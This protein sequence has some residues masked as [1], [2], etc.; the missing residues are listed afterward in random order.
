MRQIYSIASPQSNIIQTSQLMTSFNSVS[1]QT[2]NE[3]AMIKSLQAMKNL[4]V[5][6]YKLDP[7]KLSTIT[8]FLVTSEQNY[9]EL[10]SLVEYIDWLAKHLKKNLVYKNC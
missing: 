2:C 6:R 7:S 8:P 10:S 4:M 1:D 5:T 9:Q 3:S